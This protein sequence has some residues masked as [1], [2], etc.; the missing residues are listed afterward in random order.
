MSASLLPNPNPKV[1]R[2]GDKID[3]VLVKED[4]PP[5]QCP[6][7]GDSSQECCILE[8]PL[9]LGQS[10]VKWLRGWALLWGSV[11]EGHHK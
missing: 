3:K 11:E 1:N 10:K 6:S 2:W 4:Q 7:S 8:L 5:S 9:R